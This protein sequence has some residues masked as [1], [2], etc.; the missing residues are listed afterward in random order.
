ML[1]QASGEYHV[2]YIQF[3]ISQWGS[4]SE[5]YFHVLQPV[6]FI[7]S[8]IYYSMEFVEI[9]IPKKSI[10]LAAHITCGT[11]I[12]YPLVIYIWFSWK[13]K[14]YHQTNAI[15]ISILLILSSN[16]CLHFA[17]LLYLW[18]LP[19]TFDFWKLFTCFNV[20]PK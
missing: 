12:Y 14:L 2:E 11:I 18:W 19:M 4:L 10:L 1:T 6:D 8:Q 20:A 13:W 5:Q 17:F 7:C 3:S 15:T 16:N 9:G